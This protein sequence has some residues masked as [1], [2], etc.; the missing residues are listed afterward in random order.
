MMGDSYTSGRLVNPDQTF[1]ALLTQKLNNKH[2]A[3]AKPTVLAREGWRTD[4]LLKAIMDT[5]PD[6]RFNFVTLLI[7]VNNQ[8]QHKDI[9]TY[10]SEFKQLLDSAIAIAGGKA[11]HVIVLSIPDWGVTPFAVTRNP[12]KIAEEID[13]YNA[14]NKDLAK[15]VGALY[16]NITGLSRDVAND[17]ET[18]A[19]DQLH[20][21]GK[22]YNWWAD[23]VAAVIKSA[24]RKQ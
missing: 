13:A 5:K 22:M 14:I 7:G 8:F 21:S 16:I 2:I 10:R 4:E 15:Q 12:D 23:K 6:H 11:G 1:P 24:L 17:P 18:L 9:K 20:P 3:T 19:A